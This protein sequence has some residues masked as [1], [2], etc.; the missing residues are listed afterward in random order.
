MP[1]NLAIFID[2]YIAELQGVD[3]KLL[4]DQQK[5]LQISLK[6]AAD[7]NLTVVNSFIHRFEPHGI[8]LVLVISQSHLAI[9]TWPEYRYMHL[10]MM[11]C[12]EGTTLKNL[13]RILHQHFSPTTI[14]TRKIKY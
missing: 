3:A 9:H 8:S 10:D 5:L 1:K 11:T 2:H 6:V 13:Q 14:E 7:L 12:S 4:N